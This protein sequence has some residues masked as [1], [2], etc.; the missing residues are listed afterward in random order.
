MPSSDEWLQYDYRVIWN[1]KGTNY[2]ISD[3]TNTSQWKNATAS[4]VNLIPPIKRR[5]VALEVDPSAFADTSASTIVVKFMVIL[6]GKPTVQR[7]VKLRAKDPTNLHDV[8][9]FHD[10]NEIVAYQVTRF[11]PSGEQRGPLSELKDDFIL[12]GN[13]DIK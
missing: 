11:T 1:L 3:P 2:S 12:I 9:L 6:G 13:A 8:T 4:G 10:P 5:K 7:T